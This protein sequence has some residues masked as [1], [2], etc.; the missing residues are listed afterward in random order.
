MMLATALLWLPLN[1][2]ALGYDFIFAGN[3]QQSDFRSVVEDIAATLNAKS[4]SPAETGGISGFA[5][6][7]Y[8]SYVPTQDSDAWGRLV[9]ES[10]NEI[11]IV[12][13]IVEKGLPFGF[14]AGGSYGWVPGGDGRILGLNLKYEL[15]KGSIATPAV[16]VRA[17]YTKLS[18]IDQLEY[19]SR[20][21]DV[22]ISKGFGPL[23]PYAGAGYVWSDFE[24]T[25]ARIPLQDE[26]VEEVRFFVGMRLSA[27]FGITPEYERVGD[28][29]AFNLRIGLAF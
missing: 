27:V 14:Q 16:S 6:A 17:S 25:D 3:P 15:I 7:P 29:D 23:T 13:G 1:A 19:D 26:A 4:L 12:G 21:V 22:S 18:G 20:G 10:F 28:V 8:V 5:I 2:Q 11:G 24:I 9:G